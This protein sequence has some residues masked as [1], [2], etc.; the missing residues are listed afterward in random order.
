MKSRIRNPCY[1]FFLNPDYVAPRSLR[2]LRMAAATKWP[3][4]MNMWPIQAWPYTNKL[5]YIAL[6]TI[7][8]SIGLYILG[9]SNGPIQFESA[10]KIWPLLELLAKIRWV[11]ACSC[12]HARIFVK[13]PCI[14][15][16]SK[17]KT[18]T[19]NNVSCMGNW[20]TL[21]K[22]ARAMNVSGKMLPRFVDVCWNWPA[23]I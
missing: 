11:L 19:W 17:T 23:W 20:E 6:F 16:I 22:H 3:P 4:T 13:I 1:T 5:A 18:D 9:I 10:R 12:S 21:K 8:R 7:K 15:C 2:L 14:I